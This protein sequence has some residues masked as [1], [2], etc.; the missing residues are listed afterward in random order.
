MGLPGTLG[1]FLGRRELPGGYLGAVLGRSRLHDGFL[2]W[3]GLGLQLPPPPP[4]LVPDLPSTS[5]RC[6]GMP[7]FHI[8]QTLRGPSSG[9]VEKA[10]TRLS[11]VLPE[12]SP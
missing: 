4:G 8:D 9:E 7:P 10:S 12:S 1:A 11:W 6:G 2:A 5:N 3:P